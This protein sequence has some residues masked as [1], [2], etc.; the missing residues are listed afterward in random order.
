MLNLGELVAG[1]RLNDRPYTRT[2]TSAELRLRGFTRDADGRLRD[3]HGRFTTESEAM[4]RSLSR[5][6]GEG[7]RGALSGLQRLVP[8][9]A[10]VEL[11]VPAVAAVATALGS[12]AAGAV[13]A[14]IAV[15]AFTLAAQPQL[16]AVKDA[17]T[18]AEA[19]DAAHEKVL[20]KKQL[21]T[22]LAAKGGKEYKRALAEVEAA[23][24]AATEADAAAAV[25]M[26]DLPPATR[27]TA[28]AFAA[29]KGDYQDWS[30][31]LSGTT[32]PLFTRGIEILR[33]L[34]P[35][36]TPFVR[37]AASALGDLLDRVA[38]GVKSAN[39]KG[40]AADM[41][42]ASGTALRDFVLIIGNLARGF[43]GLLQA[44]LPTS[45]AVTGGL[46]GM[47]AAFAAWGVGLKNTEG[48]AS[49]LEKA[50]EG[51]ATLAVLA[52]AALAVLTAAAPLL[53]VTTLVARAF[54]EVVSNTPAPV[55]TTLVTVLAAVRIGMILYGA[56]SAVVATA[57]AVMASSTWAAIAGWTRMMAVGLMVYARIAGAAVVSAATTSAAWAGSALAAIG[58]WVAAVLRASAVAVAQFALMAARAVVWAA[59]MAAQ[60]LV[61]MGPVGWVIA[62]VVG[63]VAVIVANWD[64]IKKWTGQAWD[65]VLGKIKSVGAS[66]LSYIMNMPLVSFFLRHWDRIRTGVAT[67]VV[68]LISYVRSLPGRISS[69]LGNLGTLLVGK[70]ISIVQG[71]WNGISSMGG[72]ISSK[73]TGWAKSMIPGPIAK[74]LGI[75]SPSKVT[76][77]QGRWIARGLVEGLTGT[78]K[79]VR[80][81]AT[82]LADIVRD[83]L[84]PGKKRSAALAKISSG[85]KTLA[86]LASREASLAARLKA[87]TKSLSDQIKARDKLAADIAGGVLDAANITAGGG[88]P[89][90][91]EAVLGNLTNRL[92]QAQ[93]FATQLAK[94]REKGV[95][96]D[97]IAQIAEAGVEQG[98]GTA[99]ALATASAAQIKQINGAQGALVTAASRAGA[100]AGDAMYGAGI[101]SA[102]G[103]V[104]GLQSQQKAI[105]KQMMT[106][107]QSMSKAIR[108]ALG[109]KSPSRV[110]AQ[111]GAYTAEGLRRGIESGR[112]AVDRSM[113]SLVSPPSGFQP[114]RGAAGSRGAASTDRRTYTTYNLTQR[115]MT[116]RDLEV[117]Q[118]RQDARARVGRPR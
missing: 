42:A 20:L 83:G 18:A 38:V 77:A 92:Q 91:A 81:A 47:T 49:F 32:M 1:L 71:L 60:W 19:A 105:E 12:V 11:G 61:A 35:T 24:K 62:V 102:Q 98:L 111:V 17:A 21:A 82:K 89:T 14:G 88:G 6:I 107:A 112:R 58:T 54:G 66:I 36:L 106:I 7:A 53:G 57:N 26:Q 23:T 69:A 64:K 48:F 90:T 52:E 93:L 100:V 2:L 8:A 16:D 50:D 72:W 5:R 22:K 29:L 97:L 117:L 85:T 68:G 44:F 10:A 34:L 70:G 31:S 41:A 87:T 104:K 9:V 51:G 39:F 116:I 65:W 55:L 15:K 78:S 33:A 56:G 40:W 25:A 13:A 96:S 59:T 94:L 76:T 75:A 46:V 67:K 101:R 95:R 99:N 86:T 28:K 80:S 110:M 103:L 108:T 43:A 114:A 63:L 73:L 30:D 3:L 27:A 37:A 45:A 113:T 79:Q 74:A 118:R 115:E 4:G 84:N 109:I